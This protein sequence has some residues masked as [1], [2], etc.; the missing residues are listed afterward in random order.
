RLLSEHR[1]ET[2]QLAW[3]VDNPTDPIGGHPGSLS[4]SQSDM[5]Q[6]LTTLHNT[7]DTDRAALALH[8]FHDTLSKT[9][10]ETQAVKDAI[11]MA[12]LESQ[13]SFRAPYGDL[14]QIDFSKSASDRANVYS[15]R[16]GQIVENRQK[17]RNY[18]RFARDLHNSRE[19]EKWN[20]ALRLLRTGRGGLVSE[21]HAEL[22][23]EFGGSLGL[24]MQAFQNSKPGPAPPRSMAQPLPKASK[25]E[26]LTTLDDL[27]SRLSANKKL[28]RPLSPP[29]RHLSP[30]FM[31]SSSKKPAP[32]TKQPKIDSIFK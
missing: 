18:G 21:T 30:P 9:K 19:R 31:E 1:T 15:A 23:E 13:Q 20:L 22:L 10:S 29:R 16:Y 12:R 28:R 6:G 14:S 25:G 17:T 32:K 4:K 3:S 7:K 8:Q 27:S 5:R 26:S 2:S 11:L 24:A